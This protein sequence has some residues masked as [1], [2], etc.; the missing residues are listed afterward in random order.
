MNTKLKIG[1]SI[2]GV[3]LI[4]FL[5]SMTWKAP[6]P[7]SSTTGIYLPYGSI[8]KIVLEYYRG[9]V[10]SVYHSPIDT[11]LTITIE[12]KSYNR[13]LSEEE[14]YKIVDCLN[15]MFSQA[16]LHHPYAPVRISYSWKLIIFYDSKQVIVEN[17]G[18][19]IFI[20]KHLYTFPSENSPERYLAKLGYNLTK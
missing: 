2:F 7:P 9:D 4:L 16:S 8:E 10:I 6:P 3:I 13:S 17:H 11:E 15:Y 19:T 14:F 12:N 5:W 18:D 20:D 1:L